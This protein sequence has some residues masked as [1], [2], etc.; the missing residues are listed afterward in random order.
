M[1]MSSDKKWQKL[2]AKDHFALFK[3]NSNQVSKYKFLF[4]E[5]DI[6]INSDNNIVDEREE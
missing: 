2:L 5:Q 4:S 1:K 3:K 6:G